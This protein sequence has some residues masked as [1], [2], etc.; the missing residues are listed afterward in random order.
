GIAVFLKQPT[1]EQVRRFLG[2][3]IVAAGAAPKHLVS[4]SGVQ[5]RCESFAAWCG[6]YKIRRRF[7]AVG[8]TGSIAVIERFT[9]PLKDE[10]TRRFPIV[11]LS[12]RSF[13]RELSL[14]I[15]WYNADRPHTTLAGVTPDERYFGRRPACHKSRFEP[16]P[17]WP[18][19]S[20]CAAPQTLVK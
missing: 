6:R 19:G 13:Q 9:R 8:T 20:P 3:V 2:R 15:D 7:G 5:F 4:D 12:R 1:S 11:P 14:F 16:R 18:R 17:N 10:C